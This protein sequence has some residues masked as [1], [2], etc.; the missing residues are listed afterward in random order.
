MSSANNHILIGTRAMKN[1]IN[2]ELILQGSGPAGCCGIYQQSMQVIKI[3]KKR[4]ISY[5]LCIMKVNITG[6]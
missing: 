6:I 5:Q 2:P 3:F 1:A 4:E